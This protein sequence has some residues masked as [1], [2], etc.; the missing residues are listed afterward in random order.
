MNLFFSIFLIFFLSNTVCANAPESEIPNREPDVKSIPARLEDYYT[1]DKITHRWIWK[2]DYE[3]LVKQ[4]AK[5]KKEMALQK[6]RNEKI[7]EIVHTPTPTPPPQ[8]KPIQPKKEDSSIWN[9]L[10]ECKNKITAAID[11]TTFKYIV[12]GALV[13]IVVIFLVLFLI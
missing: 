2:E 8:I 7:A 6:L 4:R 13:V 1:Y 11:S 9:V 5:N 3:K 12:F 10:K